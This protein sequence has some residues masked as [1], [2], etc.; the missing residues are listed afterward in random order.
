MA[1]CKKCG[2]EIEEGAEFCDTCKETAEQTPENNTPAEAEAPIQHDYV[3]ETP[4][5]SGNLNIGML[6]W[7]IINFVFC[8]QPLAI[9]AFIVT[10]MAKSAA[11]PED[12]A[13][14]L[15]TAK[16]CNIIGTA[17]GA[18]LTVL[19]IVLVVV[20]EVFETVA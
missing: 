14:K 12:E 8:C 11:T 7:A 19:Y 9:A 1:N 10:I 18:V 15:K 5:G 6:V 17:G 13:K 3:P 20:V 4:K 2:A 16:L